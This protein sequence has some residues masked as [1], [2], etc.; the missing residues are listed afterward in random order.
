MENMEPIRLKLAALKRKVIVMNY[1]ALK[2]IHEIDA[3]LNTEAFLKPAAK[4]R[5]I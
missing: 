2:A 1:E 4:K 5:K 3:V